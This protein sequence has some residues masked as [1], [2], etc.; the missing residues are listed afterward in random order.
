MAKDTIRSTD[1]P[2]DQPVMRIPGKLVHS[3]RD[4]PGDA[5]FGWAGDLNGKG[6][7]CG[8]PLPRALPDPQPLKKVR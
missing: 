2:V 6:N 8:E 4:N 1:R 7:R 3:E 5:R